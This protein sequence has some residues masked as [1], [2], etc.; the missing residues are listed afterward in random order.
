MKGGD[1]MDSYHGCPDTDRG[2]RLLP[3]LIL[4]AADAIVLVALHLGL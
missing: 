1:T 3:V 4:L 2:S